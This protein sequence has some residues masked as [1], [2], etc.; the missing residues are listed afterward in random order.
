[1]EANAI[2][3]YEIVK[4]KWGEKK[5]TIVMDYL[6]KDLKK[7]IEDTI[8]EKIE[9]KDLVTKQYLRAELYALKSDIIKWVVGI[10][11]A[12]ISIII[13]TMITITKLL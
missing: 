9:G 10:W 4:E 7:N 8:E 6:E 11:I 2:K 3:V 5:A 12:S 13:T 1:M